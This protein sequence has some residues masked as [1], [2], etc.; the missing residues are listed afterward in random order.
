VDSLTEIPKSAYTMGAVSRRPL[1]VSVNLCNVYI[2]VFGAKR[3]G[4]KAIFDNRHRDLE[5]TQRALA[6]TRIANVFS[7][8]TGPHWMLCNWGKE[9]CVRVEGNG[10]P[11]ALWRE[12]KRCWAWATVRPESSLRN[13]HGD[14]ERRTAAIRAKGSCRVLGVNRSKFSKPARI[15]A[16]VR[17]H[18]NNVIVGGG[19]ARC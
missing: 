4:K 7:R 1:E 9:Y 15:E 17:K 6:K 2:S 8:G 18:F 14:T 10:G 3:Q 12:I 19:K 11:K 16:C 5:K 13:K